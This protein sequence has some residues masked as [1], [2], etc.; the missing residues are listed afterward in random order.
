ML[1]SHSPNV[2]HERA[3]HLINPAV[4]PYILLGGEQH[5][6]ISQSAIFARLSPGDAP[7]LK[8]A[9]V[10]LAASAPAA[11]RVEIFG[12]LAI[13]KDLELGLPLMFTVRLD[14]VRFS[15]RTLCIAW[16]CATMKVG[17]II[18]CFRERVDISCRCIRYKRIVKHRGLP[19]VFQMFSASYCETIHG[20]SSNN[21]LVMLYTG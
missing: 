18:T 6:Q 16:H 15:F 8:K 12:R 5:S 14:R 7:E 13:V 9:H 11:G 21:K 10:P 3:R 20:M 1:D 17:Y 4:L 19:R 2:R